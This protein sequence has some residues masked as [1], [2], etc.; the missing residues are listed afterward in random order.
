M[1]YNFEESINKFDCLLDNLMESDIIVDDV[2]LGVKDETE[3]SPSHSTDS[4]YG[5]IMTSPSHSVSST[6]DAISL[7][8]E[9]MQLFPDSLDQ[10]ITGY[11]SR[12]D[13]NDSVDIVFNCSS[14]PKYATLTRLCW[15]WPNK[16][17]RQCVDSWSYF[18]CRNLTQEN[19]KII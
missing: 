5:E 3:L 7:S 14:S 11:L 16:W 10:E 17:T 15:M 9:Q 18:S 19:A 2:D 6:E 4:G 12:D 13:S 8:D 1:E